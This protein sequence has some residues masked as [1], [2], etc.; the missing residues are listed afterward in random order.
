MSVRWGVLRGASASRPRW[1]G[2]HQWLVGCRVCF[3]GCDQCFGGRD[4]WFICCSPFCW[5]CERFCYV[6]RPGGEGGVTG[7][8][9]RRVGSLGKAN[10]A[11]TCC[12]LGAAQ[13]VSKG[14]FIGSLYR[15]FG[16]LDRK[17]TVHMLSSTTRRL[18]GLLNRKCSIDVRGVN[19]FGTAL[20]LRGS[21]RVSSLSK[22]SSGRGTHDLELSK[23]GFE[24]SGRL[25]CLTGGRYG[26]RERK[27]SHL[28]RSPFAGGRQLR[29][30]LSFLRGRGM[31]EMMSCVLFANLS[32]SATAGRLHRFKSSPDSNVS[33][34]KQGDS[35]ICVGGVLRWGGRGRSD[36]LVFLFPLFLQEREVVGLALMA[37]CGSDSYLCRVHFRWQFDGNILSVCIFR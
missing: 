20:N 34:V 1:L 30:T 14:R 15:Q 32:H 5:L 28:R 36:G 31:V 6:V 37:S 25:I 27:V 22:S 12:H 16:K 23:I 13:G 3:C 17:S 19:A 24:T 35:G 7:C 18:T 33:C 11:R 2:C 8:V 29:L 10:G 26:L 9:G 21:G 4:Q